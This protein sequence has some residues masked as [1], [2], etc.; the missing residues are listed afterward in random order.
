M[1]NLI[2]SYN[3]KSFFLNNNNNFFINYNF[4]NKMDKSGQQTNKKIFTIKPQTL[5]RAVKYGD[6]DMVKKFVENGEDI[7]VNDYSIV[8]T[9]IY[10][11][12]F[13]IVKYL[14]EN[15]TN[16]QLNTAKLLMY[17]I[18]HCNFEI[19]KYF[20]EEIGTDINIIKEYKNKYFIQN[21]NLEILKY[22]LEREV[23][24]VE[25]VENNKEFTLSRAAE[26]GDFEFVKYLCEN[27]NAHESTDILTM[28]LTAKHGHLNIIKYLIEKKFL[29][30]P[31]QYNDKNCKD[32][33]CVVNFLIE[34]IKSFDKCGVDIEQFKN[35][36]SIVPNRY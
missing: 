8:I 29:K 10:R 11:N 7:S 15:I 19:V 5:R 25:D 27:Y 14:V 1:L 16:V 18:S 36:I 24:T 4:I 21:T 2:K 23:I 3:K 17:A 28:I 22:L 33:I 34:V 20:I 12:Q 6:I 13:E 35:H 31:P 32:E 30:H 9:A 26:N